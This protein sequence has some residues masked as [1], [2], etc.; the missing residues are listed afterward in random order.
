MVIDSSDDE[1]FECTKETTPEI[2]DID[3]GNDIFGVTEYAS[4]IYQYLKKSEVFCVL[5][6]C[7]LWRS[8]LE[9]AVI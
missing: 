8:C 3:N 4:E 5:Y 7:E 6:T 9:N 2:H 1:D